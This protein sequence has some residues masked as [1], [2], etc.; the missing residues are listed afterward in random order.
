MNLYA[1]WSGSRFAWTVSI[2]LS[3]T[4]LSKVFMARGVNYT[5]LKSLSA[6]G[7]LLYGTGTMTESFQNRGT[8]WIWSDQEKMKEKMSASRLAQFLK[9]QLPIPSGPGLVLSFTFRNSL[10]TFPLSTPELITE[11]MDIKMVSISIQFI[12]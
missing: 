5:G 10:W 12:R 2:R 11:I 9:T 1:N 7:D 8:L 6:L 3:F 4:V